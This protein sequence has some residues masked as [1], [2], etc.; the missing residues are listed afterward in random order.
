[1]AGEMAF[2]TGQART[3]TIEAVSD[4][5]VQVLSRQA[6]ERMRDTHPGLASKV[7]LMVIRKLCASVVRANTLIAS[8]I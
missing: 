8:Q 3:A 6:L 2:C 4:S 5:Q 7:D 1:M